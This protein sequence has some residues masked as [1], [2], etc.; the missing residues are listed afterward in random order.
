MIRIIPAAM[1]ALLSCS[2][3]TAH[4]KSS[5]YTA[6]YQQT[7]LEIYRHIISIRSAAGHGKVPEVANY[8]ADRFRDAGFD[9]ADIHI[10]PQTLSTGEERGNQVAAV[11]GRSSASRHDCKF[12]PPDMVCAELR[13]EMIRCCP[14]VA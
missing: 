3:A 4:D 2:V 9:D 7:A 14:D 12:R 11:W 10:L 8:L 5:D 1:A 13:H 6:D